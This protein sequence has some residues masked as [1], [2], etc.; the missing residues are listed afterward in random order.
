MEPRDCAH[1][2]RRAKA[3]KPIKDAGSNPA[4]V[5]TQMKPSDGKL[6]LVSTPRNKVNVQVRGFPLFLSVAQLDRASAF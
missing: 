2:S 1:T 5:S 3:P 4:S 6:P